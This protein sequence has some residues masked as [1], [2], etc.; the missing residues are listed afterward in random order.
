MSHQIR[1]R[2]F[3][4]LVL[5]TSTTSAAAADVVLP[6]PLRL[7]D[8]TSVALRNRAEVSAAT[9]RA[10]ALAER[11]A[12]VSVLDDPMITTSISYPDESMMGVDRRYDHSVSI[13]QRFPLSRVR[14]HRRAAA[15]ADADRAKARA[16]A[17]ELDVVLDAQRNF[18]MLLER[19]RMQ[20]IVNEQIA[21]ADQLVDVAASRYA[22]GTSSQA[23]VLRAEVEVARL[24]AKRQALLAQIRGG[25]AM[26][27]ASMGLSADAPLPALEHDPDLTVPASEAEIL[28]QASTYRPELAV[29]AA[30]V[31]R[32]KA[33]I[34]VM[35]SMY[36][37]MGTVSVGRAS[38]M[39]TGDETMLMVG[40][41]LPIWRSSLRAG[42]NE[43]R[44]MQRMADAD[45]IAMHRMVAG[46]ALAAREEVSAVR[47]QALVLRT[48]VVPR[49]VA[50]TE[51][52]LA[53][54]ASGQGTLIAVV[55]SA[56]A[57]W[58]VQAEKVMVDAAVGEAWANLDRATG[59]LREISR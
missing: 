26:L 37:P 44:A 23:D 18:F 41:S 43:A 45:L 2:I 6:D 12:I 3:T 59:T 24:Q 42:V 56:R 48:E 55:E 9:A 49:A 36:R 1:T 35:R 15:L 14:A 54:Y 17:T 5:A 38:T 20:Q 40:L 33:E 58:E 28:R 30:E 51:A 8:V 53:N 39:M 52:A 31:N 29:G 25:E 57:L 13:E 47:T 22:S 7:A 46:E 32:A 4:L 16:N 27:N 34:D 11:P 19:R 50:A 21:L 10:D